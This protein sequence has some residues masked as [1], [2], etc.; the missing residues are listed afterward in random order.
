MMGSACGKVSTFL[1]WA[2][3]GLFWFIFVLSKH[4]FYRK[5]C[6]RQ[7][8]A[9]S[10]R[11]SRGWA[12][13]AQIYFQHP[14]FNLKTW[15]QMKWQVLYKDGSPGLVVGKR[16]TF[17]R[18]WVRIPAPYTGLTFVTYICCKNCNDVY[19]KRP[20]INE[21]EAGVGPFFNKKQE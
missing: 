13:W 12:R 1:K 5:N 6:R 4:K 17:R 19:L 18:L 16:F 2:Y 14:K 15:C 3:S 7:W 21:K 20:K 10:D 9:N 11:Q 8:D